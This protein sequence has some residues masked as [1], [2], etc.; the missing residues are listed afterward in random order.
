MENKTCF[1]EYTNTTS[2]T[3]RKC[4]KCH[5]VEKYINGQWVADAPQ[6]PQRLRRKDFIQLR[7]F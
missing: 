7:M 4:R 6:E 1:H 2:G 5:L 3:Y